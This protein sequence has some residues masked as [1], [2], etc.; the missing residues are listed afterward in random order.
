MIMMISCD[1][2]ALNETK[3]ATDHMDGDPY[4]STILPAAVRSDCAHG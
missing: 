3:G 4:S 1:N 2:Y